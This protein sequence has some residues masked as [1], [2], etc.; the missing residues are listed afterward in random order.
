M[1]SKFLVVFWVFFLVM[2]VMSF[3][4]SS[5]PVLVVPFIMLCIAAPLSV[6]AMAKAGNNAQKLLNAGGVKT[7]AR[8][9]Q[10]MDTG[11]TMNKTLIGIKV[12]LEV[13]SL[14]GAPFQAVVE[15]FCSRVALPR[16]GDIVEVVYNPSDTSKVAVVME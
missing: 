5:Y 15:M 4:L 13:L 10:V 7:S 9:V 12:T 8:I 14:T 2:L 1:R 11:M 16:S 6:M 3:F